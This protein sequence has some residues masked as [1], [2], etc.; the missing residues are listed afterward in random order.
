MRKTFPS[1]HD[2]DTRRHLN[3]RA[4]GTRLA[5]AVEYQARK[6]SKSKLLQKADKREKLFDERTHALLILNTGETLFACRA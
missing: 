3:R 6:R 4:H 2:R 5:K 1:T